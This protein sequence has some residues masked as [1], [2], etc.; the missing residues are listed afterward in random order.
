MKKITSLLIAVYFL[1]GAAVFFCEELAQAE[2]TMTFAQCEEA[3]G[4]AWR[5]DSLHPDICPECS[6]YYRCFYQYGDY[7]GVCPECGA[8]CEACRNRVK[9]SLQENYKHNYLQCQKC[10]TS[11]GHQFESDEEKNKL[12]PQ[13]QDYEVKRDR[14]VQ[15][16]QNCPPC[17][18]CKKCQDEKY[19]ELKRECPSMSHEC[20]Q[21][22]M[23]DNSPYS[24][25]CPGG[26][27]KIAEISDAA[28]S[29]QCC[30]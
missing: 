23:E 12:C 7:S 14:L 1:G 29:F 20:A 30:K 24:D 10:K 18:A 15:E 3:G 27:K 16:I 6:E 2:E 19:E 13:C 26:K 25:I 8:P 21:C 11:H 4:I 22:S 28:I 9:Q 17:L 5:V